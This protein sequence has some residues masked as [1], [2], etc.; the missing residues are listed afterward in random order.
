[1][2]YK[3]E[4]RWFETTP[5]HRKYMSSK[6][7]FLAKKFLGEIVKI[8]I[9]RPLGSIHPR[10]DKI[11]YESNYGYLEGVK[12]LDGDDLDAYLL[13]VNEPVQ[14]YEGVVTAVVHRLNDNDDKLVVIPKGKSIS[15]E[16][17]E[18]AI[19]FQEKWSRSKHLIIRKKSEVQFNKQ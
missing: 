7:L 2:S 10:L 12:A 18:K 8:K 4:V 6:S 1:V 15:D 14:E 16:E 11:Q 19:E 3:H 17:I 13:L 5:A 9:D